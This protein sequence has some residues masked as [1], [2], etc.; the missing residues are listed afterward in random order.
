MKRHGEIKASKNKWRWRA[1]IKHAEI[2]VERRV[3]RK[4]G[5]GTRKRKLHD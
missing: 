2:V 3:L 4:L 5:N 1:G